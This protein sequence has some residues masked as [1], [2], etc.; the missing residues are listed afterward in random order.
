MKAT[1]N[2]SFALP[3]KALSKRIR[4]IYCMLHAITRHILMSSIKIQFW[5]RFQVHICLFVFVWN[6][7]YYVVSNRRI[8]RHR[9][10]HLTCS[11]SGIYASTTARLQIRISCSQLQYQLHSLQ[12]NLN[13]N[14]EPVLSSPF[15]ADV[16]AIDITPIVQALIG[17]PQDSM[18]L[19]TPQMRI[20]QKSFFFFCEGFVIFCEIN[21]IC[22]HPTSFNTTT[23]KFFT[24]L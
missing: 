10:L 19:L 2:F 24:G 17:V 14:V 16:S 3:R 9:L 5:K 8:V 15:H 7:E 23:K 18:F 11:E 1:V 12:N 21:E 20:F 22:F 4:M 6:S 13:L